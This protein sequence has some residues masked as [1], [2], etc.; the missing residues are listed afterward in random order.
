VLLAHSKTSAP[1][2][3]KVDA[4]DFAVGSVLEQEEENHSKKPLAFFSKKLRTIQQKYSTFDRELL[5]IYLTIKQF[6]HML[7]YIS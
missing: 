5:T 3:I 2:S 4:P 1:L 7:Q 6:K